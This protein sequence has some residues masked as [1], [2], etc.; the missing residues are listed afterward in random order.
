MDF[1]V[2]ICP[3]RGRLIYSARH[4][5]C[6]LFHPDVTRIQI[7][8]RLCL[9]LWSPPLSGTMKQLA[10]TFFYVLHHQNDGLKNHFWAL[11]P[12]QWLMSIGSGH[13]NGCHLMRHPFCS[14]DCRI[15]GLSEP[16]RA[17]I[18]D[19][20]ARSRCS[21]AQIP[22]TG[23]PALTLHCFPVTVIL[24]IWNP[25]PIDCT[26]SSN[27]IVKKADL[28][29]L[30]SNWFKHQSILHYVSFFSQ[31]CNSSKDRLRS[32]F[33]LWNRTNPA[34]CGSHSCN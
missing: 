33:L 29:K 26:K 31:G 7:H 6:H 19:V 3:Q 20:S 34:R 15:V 25:S 18:C 28:T 8:Q 30:L 21:W 1:F 22:L 10:L 5:R 4:F 24:Q 2:I 32:V 12:K 17:W 11:L 27:L 13:N 16:K 23:G 14:G 9:Q